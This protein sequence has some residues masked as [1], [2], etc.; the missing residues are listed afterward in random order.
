MTRLSMSRAMLFLVPILIMATGGAAWANLGSGYFV[1]S[2]SSSGSLG[3]GL[4]NP[5]AWIVQGSGGTYLAVQH[6]DETEEFG[7]LGWTYIGSGEGIAFAYQNLPGLDDDRIQNFTLGFSG[8]NEGGGFGV[9]YNWIDNILTPEGVDNNDRWD[10]GLI[11]RSRMISFG[12]AADVNTDFAEGN[13]LADLGLRPFGPRVTLF[14]EGTYTPYFN[15]D[16]SED[17]YRLNYGFGAEIMAMPGLSISGRYNLTGFDADESSF[18]LGLQLSFGGGDRNAYIASM[19]EVANGDETSTE[20]LGGTYVVEDGRKGSILP[21]SWTG[22]KYPEVHL[23]GGLPYRRFAWFDD[24]RTFKGLLEQINRYAENPKTEGVVINLSGFGSDPEKMLELRDQLAGLRADGKKVVIYFDR[25]GLFGYMLASVADELWMDPQGDLDV[26]GLAFG[27]TYMADTL[28]K[29]GIGFQEHRY[30]KFKTAAETLARNAPSEGQRIQT[31]AL[32]E[33]WYETVVAYALESRGMSRAD[34]DKAVEEYG[35]LLPSEALEMGFVDKVGDWHDMKEGVDE[36]AMRETRDVTATQLAGLR[37][38]PVW[39]DEHWGL[40]PR[41]ALL[42]AEGGCSMDTGIRGRMLS[43]KIRKVRDDAR[44]KA[45]VLRADS[46]GGDPLPSDLVSRELKKTMEKKPVI[47]SQGFVAASGGYW[48]SMH[49]D[50][51]LASP[52]TITGS[53]G[54]ISG[55]IWDKRVGEKLGMSYH[56]SQ[57]GSHSDIYRGINLPLL[58]TLPHRPKNEAELE[59]TEYAIKFLYQDF[60]KQV[61]EGR[62]MT[63]EAVAEVAQGRVWSGIDGKD[64]GLVDELGGLWMALQMAKDAAGIDADMPVNIIEGPGLGNFDFGMFAPSL[65]GIDVETIEKAANPAAA[66]F[67]ERELEYLE[68]LKNAKG[69]PILMMEPFSIYDGAELY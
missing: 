65:L 11:K 43:K 40:T 41:I 46:P 17:E 14:G 33:D 8:G 10:I 15:A 53:I 5:A 29:L 38:D 55:H 44:V 56:G 64:N 67:N 3:A 12:L 28:E 9:S 24:G 7:D 60:I 63:E 6:P 50:K 48:I 68:A 47:I 31:D 54:V 45:V 19:G 13:Y 27:G 42:Y 51:I 61:A 20:F 22:S 52:L 69:E 32:L 66:Y 16:E 57:R 49:S 21:F 37:G 39:R 62:G 58:G 4:V 2:P 25:A 18:S 1:N 26:K 35:E 59:R 34:W 30:F 36:I 23:K